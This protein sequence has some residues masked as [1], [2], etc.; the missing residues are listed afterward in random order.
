MPQRQMSVLNTTCTAFDWN[1]SIIFI[2]HT[3]TCWIGLDFVFLHEHVE[4]YLTICPKHEPHCEHIN[5][6]IQS[7]PHSHNYLSTPHSLVVGLSNRVTYF[8]D[9]QQNMVTDD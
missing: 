9:I 7:Y 1:D 3:I 4:I 5:S 2:V 6:Y 8:Y